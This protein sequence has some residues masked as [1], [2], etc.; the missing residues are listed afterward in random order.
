MAW[1]VQM[2]G[3]REVALALGSVAAAGFE[4]ASSRRTWLAASMI[5]D[6]V[7]ATALTA[8]VT[9]A[10]IGRRRGAVVAASAALLVI[11][12]AALFARSRHVFAEHEHPHSP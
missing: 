1:A 12:E 4:P 8:A 3:G 2:V 9:A 10:T 5:S 11:A 7:D 6:A